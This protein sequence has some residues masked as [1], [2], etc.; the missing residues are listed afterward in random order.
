MFFKSFFVCWSFFLISNLHIPLVQAQ[1]WPIR[2][3]KILIPS[4]PGGGTD[5]LARIIAVKL[6]DRFGQAF[7]IE[8]RTGAGGNVAG[9]V[10]FKSAPDGYTIMLT[11]PSP[12]V[13]NKALYNSLNYD[14]ELFSTISLVATV[15]NVFIVSSKS[16]AS[17]I[18]QLIAIAK[19]SA[20]KLNYASG[21]IG[22]T[23]HL[24]SELFNSMA[25]IEVVG[26]PHQGSSPA[27]LAFLG[28]Q[29]DMMF[30]ELSTVLPYIHSGKVRA[31]GVSGNKRTSY[32]TDVP[33]ISE[34]LPGFSGAVWFGIVG[35]PK[36]PLILTEDLSHAVS[37]VL[38]LPDVMKQLSDMSLDAVGGSPIDLANFMREESQRWADVIRKS[39]ARAN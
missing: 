20:G 11:H 14:P 4:P 37:E 17:N 39:G 6:K 19:A 29:V 35:P 18:R 10:L 12:L 26:I 15:P 21:G 7:L 24:A 16:S 32:L 9:E 13:I 30:I 31:L 5:S 38:K 23:S 2:P 1:T 36:M 27:L 28:G 25:G 22:S 3:V 8:N 34:T 33:A